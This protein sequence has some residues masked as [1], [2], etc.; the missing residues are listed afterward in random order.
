MVIGLKDVAPRA[1]AISQS[2]CNFNFPSLPPSAPPRPPKVRSPFVSV[3]PFSI[4]F[5]LLSPFVFPF[6]NATEAIKAPPPPPPPQICTT[7]AFCLPPPNGPPL[8]PSL[9]S[10]VGRLVVAK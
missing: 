10:S 5:L 7:K 2:V 8:P 9:V 4:F 1:R 3:F 6:E